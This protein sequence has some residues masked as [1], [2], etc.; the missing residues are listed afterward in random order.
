MRA[1]QLRNLS[2]TYDNGV[3]A[4]KGIDLDV[5]EG[6]FCALLGPNGAGKT[7]AI[8]ILTSLVNKTGGS[9]SVFGYDIDTDLTM[10]KSCLGLVPQEINLNLFE[11][12]INIVVT[13]AGYYGIPRRIA[14]ERAERYLTQLHLWDR[15]ESVARTLS[16]GMKRRLMIA[17]ALIHEPRLLIL[18]EPTAGV[19]IEIR[20]SMWGFLR[21]INAEG[22]TIILTT[23][24][25]EE[26]ENLCRQVAI[27]DEGRI[28]ENDRMSNVLRKLAVET[29]VLNLDQE[30]ASVPEVPG[31][32]IRSV[33]PT[34]VEVDVDSRRGINDLFTALTGH[35]IRVVSMRNKSNRL[36]ELFMKLV[37]SKEATVRGHA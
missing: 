32:V 28:I 24:Y 11:K 10:A 36:E 33:D 31:Y 9:V 35:G 29:F 16:G 13:Q 12:V 20:R 1:L 26:A 4:L 2:K 7:T 30:V 14:M 27:I 19:D 25:L 22:T 37:D 3:E 21:R 15:R 8:G 17:R 5:E 34:T 23:H 18:D 6:E